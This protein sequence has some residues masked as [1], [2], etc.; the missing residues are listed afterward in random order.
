MQNYLRAN[1]IVNRRRIAEVVSFTNG[2]TAR[3]VVHRLYTDLDSL[4]DFKKTC[5]K[6][7]VLPDH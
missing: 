3:Y 7:I 5:D 2:H 1:H 4:G 6:S